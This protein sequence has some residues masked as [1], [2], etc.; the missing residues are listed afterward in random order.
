MRKLAHTSIITLAQ[1][2]P[3]ADLEGNTRLAVSLAFI[4]VAAI[5]AWQGARSTHFGTSAAFWVAGLV[6]AAGFGWMLEGVDYAIF[7]AGAYLILGALAQIYALAR[8]TWEVGLWGIVAGLGLVAI[9][10]VADIKTGAFA[11][12]A[13][14]I[15]FTAFKVLATQKLVHA[16]LWL[17]GVL[18]GIA[19]IFLSLGA[20]FLAAIQILV[21]VGAVITLFLF[22]VMLTEPTEDVHGLDDLELPPGVHVES[23]VDLNPATPAYGVGPFKDLADTNP[24]KPVK[25]P[26][27]LYGVALTDGV[28]GRHDT[29]R[30]GENKK[31]E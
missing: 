22:T 14:L 21:Y 12:S 10:A 2:A 11:L 17:A 19:G 7:T 5:L 1:A 28:H 31:E 24:R 13:A 23:I 9:M 15:V 25:A 27:T 8:G 30:R 3:L 16:A 4:A 29:V 6:V 20:E 26:D 18:I